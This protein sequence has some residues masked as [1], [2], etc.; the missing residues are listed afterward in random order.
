[1]GDTDPNV[2]LP[3][4]EPEPEPPT[5]AIR[6]GRWW[7][8]TLIGGS[9]V[10]LAWHLRNVLTPFLLAFLLA[11]VL[12]R[13][14]R[15][16]E[17]VK[18]PRAIG[19]LLVF[20]VATTFVVWLVSFC[21]SYFTAELAEAGR[22]LPA[23]AEALLK[24]AQ[25]TLKQLRIQVPHSTKELVQQ[26]GQSL[27]DHA[28]DVL[29]WIGTALFGTLSYAFVVLSL[30][31]I[32]IFAYYILVDFD[33]IVARGGKLVP[34]RHRRLVFETIGEI[35]D[36]VS[37]Y[38]RGQLLAMIVLSALYAVGLQ[39]LG[40]RLAIPIGVLTGLLAF[41]PYL[42]FVV[43]LLI[44]CTMAAIDAQNLP[45]VVQVAAVMTGVH[46]LDVFVVTPRA[47]GRSVGLA[48]IEVLLAMAAAGTLFG[49]V[50]VLFAVPI[51]ATVKIVARRAAKAYRESTFY[52]RAR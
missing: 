23:Q 42:G 25:P 16:L 37:G 47:V 41:I 45:F 32:P 7:F 6:P 10:F 44:A 38:M 26:Y 51:G 9:L 13:P 28:P 46:I 4:I 49:F 48:S 18:I 52:R 21:A 35:D 24:K 29:R 11:W 33:R 20:L 19:A 36:M 27:K 14:V 30:L 31:I 40:L 1:M 22:H 15:I 34:R 17:K 12:S 2:T 43:G 50:G 8:A 5:I 39:L 3:P